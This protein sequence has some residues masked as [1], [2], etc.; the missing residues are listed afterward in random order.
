MIHANLLAMLLST[1]FTVEMILLIVIFN[2]MITAISLITGPAQ[3]L[4]QFHV[5]LYICKLPKELKDIAGL[6]VRQ[7]PFNTKTTP[8]KLLVMPLFTNGTAETIFSNVF[9]NA[10]K[11]AISLI[12]EHVQ[13]SQLLVASHISKSPKELKDIAS[14]HV[15]QEAFTTRITPVKLIAISL[16]MNFTVEMI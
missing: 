7:E 5:A 11:I 2:V 14:L 8:A 12:M 4:Q 6:I 15:N 1:N 3:K 9:F 13:I 16:S 10:L